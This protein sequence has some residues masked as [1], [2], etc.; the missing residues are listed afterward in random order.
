MNDILNLYDYFSTK[1]LNN[2]TRLFKEYHDHNMPMLVT[3]F[4]K[5]QTVDTKNEIFGR[6]HDYVFD[7]ADGLF[8]HVVK[9]KGISTNNRQTSTHRNFDQRQGE[10]IRSC[11]WSAWR[12]TRMKCIEDYFLVS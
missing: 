2:M 4:C 9:C 10:I 11:N 6:T 7:K 5:Q 1:K 3:F 12:E 8:R